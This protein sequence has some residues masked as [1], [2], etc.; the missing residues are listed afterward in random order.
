MDRLNKQDKTWAEFSTLDVGVLANAV[1]W[2]S[3]QKQ[4]NLKLK[5]QPKQ[6]MASLLLAFTLPI[7]AHL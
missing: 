1:Q 7:K 3:L 2:P 6:L 5:S 4:P